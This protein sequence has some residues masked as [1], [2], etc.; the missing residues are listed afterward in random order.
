MINIEKF[1][2]TRKKLGLSQT[3]LCRGIC[4]QSTLSKFESNGRIPSLKILSD[5]CSKMDIT[6]T[7]IMISSSDNHINQMLFDADFATGQYDFSKVAR[8]LSQIKLENIIHQQD[9][10]HYYYLR[11]LLA[12]ELDHDETDAMY[13]FESILNSDKLRSNSLYIPLALCGQSLV[14]EFQK[15]TEKADATFQD[16]LH[17]LKGCSPSNQ[18]ECLQI[19]SILCLAGEFYGRI[20]N[21]DRSN[22]ILLDAYQLCSQMHVTFF[23]ARV[24]YQL[25]L[26]NQ[27]ENGSSAKTEL[28]LQDSYAFARLNKNRFLIDKIKRITN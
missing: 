17:K 24:M 13:Y 16:T 20:K 2:Q 28:Y 14:Y 15:E 26:N 1:I 5:L 10:Y 9:I 25:A 7:D 23:L 8:I 18:E 19:L 11:G 22:E 4:T 3:E 12:L 6:L 27:S 21:F